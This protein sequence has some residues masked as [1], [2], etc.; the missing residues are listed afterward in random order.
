MQHSCTD[1]TI[2]F[3]LTTFLG[4]SFLLYTGIFYIQ[5]ASLN[6]AG[7]L[8]S[9]IIVT[10]I[11]C[12]IH[13]S[14]IKQ[15][16][17]KN[18]NLCMCVKLLVF[19]MCCMSTHNVYLRTIAVCKFLTLQL[20][21]IIYVYNYKINDSNCIAIQLLSVSLQLHGRF[22]ARIFQKGNFIP[23]NNIVS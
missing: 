2:N 13:Q 9:Y 16:Y 19:I 14:F 17:Y 21:L 20:Y 23:Q 3:D 12:V 10:C 7:Y 1:L 5:L 22:I 18:V 4:N 15:L 6:I 8:L 11:D